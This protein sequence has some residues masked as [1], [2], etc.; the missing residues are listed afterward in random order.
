LLRAAEGGAGWSLTIES[1]WSAPENSIGARRR[2]VHGPA[3]AEALA[4][5][6][7]T[8]ERMVHVLA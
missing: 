4:G 3:A 8:T 5:R 1:D 6:Q 2:V 7:L